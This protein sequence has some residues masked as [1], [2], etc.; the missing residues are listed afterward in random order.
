M[1]GGCR[2][3]GSHEGLPG[4]EGSAASSCSCESQGCLSASST[5]IRRR[6]SNCRARA[7]GTRM[8]GTVGGRL[9]WAA[10]RAL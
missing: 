5:V 10:E 4:A 6:G 3:P 9:P 8:R 1:P 7:A 2:C